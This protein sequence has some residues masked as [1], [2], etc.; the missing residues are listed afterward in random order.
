MERDNSRGCHKCCSPATKGSLTLSSGTSSVAHRGW[1]S[2]SGVIALSDHPS[3]KLMHSCGPAGDGSLC[4]PNE[5]GK[6]SFQMATE[7]AAVRHALPFPA[8][9]ASGSPPCTTMRGVQACTNAVARRGR[10]LCAQCWWSCTMYLPTVVTRYQVAWQMEKVLYTVNTV[11]ILYC[12]IMALHN[13]SRASQYQ[14][15]EY[16]Q[17]I[18]VHIYIIS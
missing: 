11:L 5:D 12:T 4:R 3:Q 13:C 8:N 7:Q 1:C 14:Y 9:F 17:K 10:Q 16:A 2:S 18:K 15:D 6:T